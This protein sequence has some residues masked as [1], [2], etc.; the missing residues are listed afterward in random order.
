LSAIFISTS[1]FWTGR[2][3]IFLVE[4]CFS[5][6]S[7]TSSGYSFSFCC[8]CF[9]FMHD[10]HKKSDIL[11]T[12]QVVTSKLI[13]KRIIFFKWLSVRELDL[14]T[15][16]FV[17]VLGWG[18]WTTE[19][20]KQDDTLFPWRYKIKNIVSYWTESIQV[21]IWNGKYPIALFYFPTFYVMLNLF[22]IF[23][24]Q[25]KLTLYLLHLMKVV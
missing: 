17:C 23:F 15:L 21:C 25:R 9:L 24:M 5:L 7:D 6:M 20:C 8:C 3:W 10:K 4:V 16:I 11:R 13:L 22:V 19:T 18:H 1:L 2:P 12:K 14:L